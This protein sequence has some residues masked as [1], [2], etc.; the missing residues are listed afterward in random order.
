M[1]RDILEP[2]PYC[3]DEDFEQSVVAMSIRSMVFWQRAG[4]DIEPSLLGDARAQLAMKAARA[5]AIDSKLPPSTRLVK[6]RLTT[7]HQEG[8]FGRDKLDDVVKY[9]NI[10]TTDTFQ[11]AV[12]N[13]LVPILKRRYSQQIAI[14]AAS[15]YGGGSEFKGTQ[16]LLEKLLQLG[17]DVLDLE[18]DQIDLAKGNPAEIARRIRDNV[19]VEKLPWGVPEVDSALRGGFGRGWTTMFIGR[20]GDGKTKALGTAACSA[21]RRGK[22]VFVATLELSPEEMTAFLLANL[23]GLTFDEVIADPESAFNLARMRLGGE[24]LNLQVHWFEPQDTT[25]DDVVGKMEE[26][27]PD[28]DVI[29]LDYIDKLSSPE[30]EKN[31]EITTYREGLTVAEKFR[32]FC[33]KR[34]VWGVTAS[35]STRGDRKKK[36]DTDDAADSLHKSRVAD[37][38]ITLSYDDDTSMW[39]CFLAKVRFGRGRIHL[40]PFPHDWARGRMAPIGDGAPMQA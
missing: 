15:E 24:P 2:E 25:I 6:Q 31:P 27:M 14:M 8:K 26:V 40:G 1:S 10:P 19:M 4:H 18:E 13:E 32:L 22:S 38:I 39:S 17:V 36:L 16:K 9:L 5:V 37:N 35:Q 29:V 20:T 33:R 21:L 23:S 28:A 11:T 12:L 34:K 7:L 30:R 3:F